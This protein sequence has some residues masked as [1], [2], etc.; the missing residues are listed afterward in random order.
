M[1]NRLNTILILF[2]LLL[3]CSAFLLYR[4]SKQLEAERN[5]YQHNTDA[6]ISDVKRLRV[7]S[8]TTAIDIKTLRLTLDEYRQYRT[9]DAEKIR[10]LGV[11]LSDLQMAAKHSLEINAPL[12]ASIQDSLIIRD[13]VRVEVKTLEVNTPYLQISGVIENS[14]LAGNIHLPVTLHQ[15]VWIE[16]KHR[17]LC[18]RWGVKAVHQTVAS[19]NP[20]VE[21]KYSEVIE[22]RK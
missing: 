14:R 9:E 3:G 21:I 19:D 7:D 20:H 16:H 12:E 13:T 22:I 8:T 6:L 4:H 5:K 1:I 2:I 17:F 10:K 15:A 18:W 11:K